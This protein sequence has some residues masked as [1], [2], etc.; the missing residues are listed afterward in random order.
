MCQR[1]LPWENLLAQ[2]TKAEHPPEYLSAK[3]GW[4]LSL[5]SKANKFRCFLLNLS[6]G[7]PGSPVPIHSIAAVS[8]GII[9]CYRGQWTSQLWNLFPPSLWQLPLELILFPKCLISFSAATRKWPNTGY[10]LPPLWAFQTESAKIWKLI[11]VFC[12]AFS[13]CQYRKNIRS[14][15]SFLITNCVSHGIL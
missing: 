14:A 11:Y 1:D 6:S 5:E 10:L 7:N 4:S 15:M 3:V 9:L 2:S 13:L 12:Q 8:V